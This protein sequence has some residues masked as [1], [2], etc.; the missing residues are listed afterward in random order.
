MRVVCILTLRIGRFIFLF[1]I[2]HVISA[3]GFDPELLHSMSYD[4]SAET[5]ARLA[6]MWTAAG[7][8]VFHLQENQIKFIL[9]S[10]CRHRCCATGTTHST[11]NLH[12]KSALYCSAA[13]NS[14][15]WPC[16]RSVRS[17]VVVRCSEMLSDC[18]WHLR[19]ARMIHQWP[20]CPDTR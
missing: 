16:T 10:I 14:C 13:P 7:F 3:A 17:H 5:N 11:Y 2:N 15:C 4:F 9:I 19:D 12:P 8:T 6:K 20:Y 1:S 18:V